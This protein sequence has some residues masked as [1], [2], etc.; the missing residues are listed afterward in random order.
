MQKKEKDVIVK[1]IEQIREM[2]QLTTKS[3]NPL[4]NE[5]VARVDLSNYNA[6]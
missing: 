1:E 6:T 3:I 4:G 5:A 2:V